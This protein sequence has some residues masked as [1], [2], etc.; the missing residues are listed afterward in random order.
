MSRVRALAAAL[1]AGAIVSVGLAAPAAAAPDRDPLAHLTAN[2]II[3]R[4]EADFKKATSVHMSGSAS[5]QGATFSFSLTAT[6]HACAE[7]AS[8]GGFGPVS[9]IQIGKTEWSQLTRQF[10]KELGYSQAQIAAYSGKWLKNGDLPGDSSD[11]CDLTSGT[12]VP[13]SGWN[14]AKTTTLG[15]HRAVELVDRKAKAIAYVS[16]SARPEYLKI[17]ADGAWLTMSRY[18]AR[19]T[20]SAPPASEVV[21]S[22]PPPPG[23]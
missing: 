18:N 1:A 7:S 21:T 11:G 17:F 4:T 10:L 6:R 2:Q 23:L 15:G 19:V 20:I 8:F 3:A 9:I 13:V 5:L 12:G 22:L 14:R 16:D